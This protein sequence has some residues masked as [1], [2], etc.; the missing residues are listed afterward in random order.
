[1]SVVPV[2]C[3]QYLC[4]LQL[5]GDEQMNRVF[6]YICQ[7]QYCQYICQYQYLHQYVYQ[8]QYLHQSIYQ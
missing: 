8:H 5:T 1:M 4:L 3:P 6:Q 7:Y 2:C